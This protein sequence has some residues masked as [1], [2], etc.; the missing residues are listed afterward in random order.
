MMRRLLCTV[1]VSVAALWLPIAGLPAADGLQSNAVSASFDDDWV[2]VNV[3]GPACELEVRTDKKPTALWLDGAKLE[4]GWSFSDESRMT[5]VRLAEGVHEIEIALLP[6]PKRAIKEADIPLTDAGGGQG[7][8]T[9]KAFFGVNGMR[10]SGVFSGEAGKY[11]LSVKCMPS[12]RKNLTVSLAA[13]GNPTA[14]W[15]L[16]RAKETEKRITLLLSPDAKLTLAVG[17]ARLR[18]NPVLGVSMKQVAA[19]TALPHLPAD[20]VKTGEG[21]LVEGEAFSASGGGELKRSGGG[22]KGAHGNDNVYSFGAPGQWIEWKVSVPKAGKYRLIV[23]GATD[24]ARPIRRLEIDGKLPCPACE[25]LQ[26]CSTG[27]WARRTA[28]EWWA[29]RVADPSGK[30]I[31]LEL[32][33][34]EHT[35]RLTVVLDH[36]LNVDYLLLQPIE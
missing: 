7:F 6:N 5:R 15:D 8:G 29:F 10:A 11:D 36:H 31:P 25:L 32:G 20:Q 34:G 28:K 35:L 4:E 2:V 26:F 16:D 23:V 13:E 9:L 18:T 12:G 3:R 24:H 33:A 14:T 22:H 27:G 1:W 19:F 30:D 17:G 21:V